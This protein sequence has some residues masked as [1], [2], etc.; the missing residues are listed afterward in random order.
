MVEAWLVGSEVAGVTMEESDEERQAKRDKYAAQKRY[1]MKSLG[2]LVDSNRLT[3]VARPERTDPELPQ[4]SRRADLD[5]EIEPAPQ[6]RADSER[7]V[8]PQ[9]ETDVDV[10]TESAADATIDE[11]VDPVDDT[12][13]GSTE[14]PPGL[15]EAMVQAIE[16]GADRPQRAPVRRVTSGAAP[17]PSDSDADADED[18]SVHAGS[19]GVDRSAMGGAVTRTGLTS[20]LDGSAHGEESGDTLPPSSLARRMLDGEIGPG[21][22]ISDPRDVSGIVLDLAKDVPASVAVS[23][24]RI[25]EEVEIVGD[26][27]DP[28]IDPSIFS[29]VFSGVFRSVRPAAQ[30]L[31]DGPLGQI[32]DVVIEG[33]KMDLILRPLG[34]AYYLMVLEDRRDP[35]ANLSATRRRMASI[36]PG[37]TAILA[38]QDGEA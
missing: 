20:R 26:T 2:R 30:I 24:V 15:H 9:A 34:Y 1:N 27:V 3:G 16:R 32:Q 31:E 33:D 14:H 13:G 10:E 5:D 23:V 38:Q 4:R 7:G 22:R 25:A 12:E 37:V 6:G 19:D 35:K 29:M 36:A 18:A 8:E 21:G 28:S 17:K 11:H